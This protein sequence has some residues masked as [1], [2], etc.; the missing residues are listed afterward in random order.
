MNGFATIWIRIPN[1]VTDVLSQAGCV[2]V[3]PPCNV[4]LI[5]PA[6]P[7]MAPMACVWMPTRA[8]LKL[9]RDY[10]RRKRVSTMLLDAIRD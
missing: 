8:P 5:I 3:Q 10:A 2:L 4:A 9:L 6:K 1:P 7:M